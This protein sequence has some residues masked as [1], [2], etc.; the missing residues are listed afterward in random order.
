MITSA[1]SLAHL[2]KAVKA[3]AI[4]ARALFVHWFLSYDRRQLLQA[5]RRLGVRDGDTLMLHAG[6]SPHHGY[7]GTIET[8][9]ETLVEAVGPAGHLLMVS[10]PYRSSSLQYLE[11]LRQFDVRRT[12]SMMGMVSEYFRRRPEVLRSLHPT[13]PILARGPRAEDFIRGHEDCI[14]PCGPGTPF[15]RLAQADG[16]VAFLNVPFGTFTFFHYLEHLVAPKLPFPL[17]TQR[18]Y[19]VPVIDRD[20]HLRTVRTHVYTPETI[21]RRRFE[22]LENA[23]RARNAI[24]R[25]SVGNTVIEAV[26]VQAA[27]ACVEEMTLRSEFFYDLSSL[28]PPVAPPPQRHPIKG[29]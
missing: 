25:V 3:R 14:H 21:S 16:L 9:T 4:A 20:G 5:L 11:K 29:V 23:L 10:L 22:V 19:E 13:H 8:L 17:Y 27:I 26:R 18:C 1:M 24:R 15:D 7:R 6:F 28:T 12:P 2:R